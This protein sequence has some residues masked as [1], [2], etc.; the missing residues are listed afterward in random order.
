MK[1]NPSMNIRLDDFIEV[2]I[3]NGIPMSETKALQIFRTAVQY[4]AVNRSVIQTNKSKVTAEIRK[5]LD[6]SSNIVGMFNRELYTQ[7]ANLKHTGLRQILANDPLY[8]YIEKGAQAAEVFAHKFK[9]D[10]NTGVSVFIQILL[11]ITARKFNIKRIVSNVDKIYDYYICTQAINNDDNKNGTK[12]ME[13]AYSSKFTRS[14]IDFVNNLL[15]D[16][17]E[18][19][20]LIF[21]RIEADEQGANYKDW[22]SSQ[23]EGL[24]FT[25]NFPMPSQL[26]GP[27]SVTRF[28][29]WKVNNPDKVGTATLN[30]NKEY[31]DWLKEQADKLRQ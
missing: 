27:T 24:D 3:D 21:A 31:W 1:R 29:R 9:L 23:F 25:G 15:I 17:R 13:S 20:N 10:L 4:S 26:H 2:C 28:L 8:P 6:R 5:R 12:L 30:K 7:R 18:K 16:P 14:Q 11:K 22:V 19:A